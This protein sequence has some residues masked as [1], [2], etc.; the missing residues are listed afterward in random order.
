MK[1]EN[2]KS[3]IKACKQN[4]AN[5]QMQLYDL[6]AKS[7]YNIALRYV[8]QTD[9]AEDMMQEAFIKAFQKIDS[10]N[11]SVTFGAWLKRI[12]I[13]HSIDYLKKKK[14][15]LISLDNKVMQ[16]ADESDAWDFT[17]FDRVNE[18]IEGINQLPNKYRVIMQLFYL[19][20]YDHQEISDILKITSVSSRTQLL[21]GKNKLRIFLD[22]AIKKTD[23]YAKGY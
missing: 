13:N 6:Y 4:D 12:V 23:N 3:L 17:R 11:E 5:A 19:E 18:V 15:K 20:G 9:I 2:Q 7:M 1:I 22:N 21:R 8:K 10:F 16:I 14:I